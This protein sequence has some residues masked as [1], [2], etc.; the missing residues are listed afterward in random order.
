MDYLVYRRDILHTTLISTNLA[1][2][3]YF[4]L[5]FAISTKG[6]IKL[7]KCLRIST[8]YMTGYIL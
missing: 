4:V 2:Y 3:E 5:K 8:S 6:D 1:Q 7:V